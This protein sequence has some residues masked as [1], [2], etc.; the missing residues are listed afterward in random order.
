MSFLSLFVG[1]SYCI[2]ALILLNY[3]S[4]KFLQVMFRC[5][6][7]SK[8]KN[9]QESGEHRDLIDHQSGQWP[10]FDIINWQLS[11]RQT[12]SSTTV[13]FRTTFTAP[14][15]SYST[16]LLMKWHLGLTFHSN[17][18]NDKDDI[19]NRNN[20]YVTIIIMINRRARVKPS[21]DEV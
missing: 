15:R 19:S 3:L 5:E 16:N 14:G 8:C 13:L 9:A 10:K 1:S 20:N 17:N 7:R 12:L 11:K 4:T 18:N 6:V 2:V 21:R